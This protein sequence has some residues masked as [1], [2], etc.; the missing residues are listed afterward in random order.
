MWPLWESG[1]TGRFHGIDVLGAGAAAGGIALINSTC[2]ISGYVA[3]Q[4]T[5]VLRDATGGYMVPLL[6]TGAVV[7][8]GAGLILASGIRKHI[9]RGVPVVN[10]AGLS[11]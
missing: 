6:V 8:S 1:T 2:N 5:G 11:H 3:P 9:P 10:S 4:V 7:L